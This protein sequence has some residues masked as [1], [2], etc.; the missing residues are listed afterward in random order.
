M[1]TL[2]MN[3]TCEQ[4]LNVRTVISRDRQTS[5]RDGM[6]CIVNGSPILWRSKLQSIVAQSTCEA[7][8]VAAACA[9]R[10]GLWIQKL[11]ASV[12]GIWRPISLYC[13]NESAL[14]LLN[15]GVPEVTG[16]TKHIDEQ[17]WFVLDHIMKGNIVPQFVRTEE[18]KADGFTKPYSGSATEMNFKR[19]GMWPK[20]E[21]D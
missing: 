9:V 15:S 5:T 18:M 16:R 8:F 20:F 14:S 11:A 4:S 1:I 17:F 2:V 13:D 12:T 19:I 21:S 3:H 6:L 7:E 10:E